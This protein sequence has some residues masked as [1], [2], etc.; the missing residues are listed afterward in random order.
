LD[1][2]CGK[3]PDAQV[4][5]NARI[6][7]LS[8]RT[9]RRGFVVARY[10]VDSAAEEYTAGYAAAGLDG[11]IRRTRI[12]L[13]LKLLEDVD[14]GR[15][16]DAGSGPGVLVH[17]L[18][19]S[20]QHDF[21]VTAL[22]QSPVMARYCIDNAPERARGKVT[23]LVGDLE[24]LP[25]ADGSF[26]VTLATGSLEYTNVR[27]AIAEISRVT[28]PAGMAVISMLNPL[29][30]YWLTRW[31]LSAPARQALNRLEASL[32]FHSTRRHGA[33]AT[34]IRAHR[35]STIRSLFRQAGFARTQ[36]IYFSPTVLVPPF[37]RHPQLM[38]A[39]DRTSGAI[40]PFGLTNLLAT[41]YL[42]VALRT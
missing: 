10:N 20:P 25:F 1:P 40:A 11:R 2:G 12:E 16:L 36:V 4:E 31:Y 7:N 22:D 41:S 34:G 26:D 6:G 8:D 27:T 19:R 35:A 32:R 29:S 3:L 18:L 14:H 28:T 21:T 5:P 23:A 38:R 39:A 42:I 15:L 17:T 37:D 9:K 13:V 33:N 24:A 30:P